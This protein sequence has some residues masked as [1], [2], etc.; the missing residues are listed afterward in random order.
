MKIWGRKCIPVL[1]WFQ[2]DISSDIRQNPVPVGFQKMPSSASLYMSTTALSNWRPVGRIRLAIP[3]NLAREG[4]SAGITIQSSKDSIPGYSPK[5][6]EIVGFRLHW[7]MAYMT[8][9]HVLRIVTC[10]H[11]SLL[12]Y[13]LYVCRCLLCTPQTP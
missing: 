4:P 6:A 2:L 1:Y 10:N 9:S 12:I 11:E 3:A 8:V 7:T 13:F 5:L